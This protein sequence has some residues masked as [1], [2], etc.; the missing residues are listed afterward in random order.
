SHLPSAL[1]IFH[2]SILSSHPSLTGKRRFAVE[3]K[4]QHARWNHGSAKTEPARTAGTGS[5]GSRR[6]GRRGAGSAAWS[7][8][9]GNG[10]SRRSALRSGSGRRRRSRR[11][12]ARA[13]RSLTAHHRDVLFAV[14]HV[15]YRRTH[16]S[17]LT[18][19]KVEKFLSLV[20]GIC[21]QPSIR[22]NL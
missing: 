17:A 16:S 3:H 8:R 21:D 1:I 5:A 14:E 2:Q 22:N 18:G 9:S 7:A 15:S 20:R 12:A 11:R 6:A 10:C 4:G 19:L 13:E